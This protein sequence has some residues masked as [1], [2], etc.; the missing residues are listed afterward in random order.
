MK[1]KE[2]IEE[3]SFV[4]NNPDCQIVS[5]EDALKAIGMAVK[6][7]KEKAVEAFIDVFKE[8]LG[9]CYQNDVDRFEKKLEE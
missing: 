2:F 7:T 3:Q 6:E 4:I 9:A 5:K 1:A 8:I